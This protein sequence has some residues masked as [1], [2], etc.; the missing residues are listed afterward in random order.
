MVQRRRENLQTFTQG[1]YDTGI[2]ALL[3]VGYRYM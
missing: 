3:F 2:L 1:R